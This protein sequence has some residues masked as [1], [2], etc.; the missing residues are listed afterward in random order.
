MDE[1]DKR[2]TAYHEAGHAIIQ[3]LLD[4]GLLPVHKVTIIPRGQSLGSTMMLPS[5]DILN[6]SKTHLLNQICT[7][8]GGR[9]AEEMIFNE[10]SSGASSDIRSATK[11]ARR[12][13]CDWG[14]SALGP[15]AFGDNRDHIFLG[16]EIAREQNY[17]ERT[18]QRIDETIS[19]IIDEQYKRACELLKEKKAS[20]EILAQALLKY[21][22]LEGSHVKEILETGTL[23]TEALDQS[24]R[25]REEA[26]KKAEK[27]QKETKAEK[28]GST[29]TADK[30][31][32]ADDKDK[33]QPEKSK[34]QTGKK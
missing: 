15:I 12:M 32:K 13:V 21:E 24:I 5:K 33:N 27:E 29:T 3:A 17:S 9:V 34:E 25:A 10:Q 14:M 4:D 28:D 23:N 6:Y 20:L 19:S 31:K 16:E 26:S 11:M 18:A 7:S 2:I 8:L 22:T 1:K 30:E